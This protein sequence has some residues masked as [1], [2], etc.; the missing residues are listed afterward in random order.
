[1][2]ATRLRATV[3]RAACRG[4]A[5]CTRRAP[6]TFSRDREGR[7]VAAD[8]PGDQEEALRQAEAHCPNFAIRLMEEPGA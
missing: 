1:M 4:A 8:P 6:R 7:A 3:D 2:S 5:V